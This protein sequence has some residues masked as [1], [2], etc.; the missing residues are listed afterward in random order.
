MQKFRKNNKGCKNK[1]VI[2][3]KDKWETEEGSWLVS[4]Q[5]EGLS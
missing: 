3:D 2:N 4:G 5:R 1:E